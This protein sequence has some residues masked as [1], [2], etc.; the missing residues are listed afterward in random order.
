MQRD[1]GRHRHDLRAIARR[2]MVER[3]LLPDFS[4]AVMAEEQRLTEA[5]QKFRFG[6]GPGRTVWVSTN[7]VRSGWYGV[8][9]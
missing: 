5:V 1:S 4:S 9:L 3:D 8:R 2:V 7:W 6:S